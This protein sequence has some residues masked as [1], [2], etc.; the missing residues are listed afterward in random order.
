MSTARVLSTMFRLVHLD[1]LVGG[2]HGYRVVRSPLHGML[3]RRRCRVVCPILDEVIMGYNCTV[4]AYRQTGT[5]KTF[6]MEGEQSR[7]LQVTNQHVQDV[8][9]LKKLYEDHRAL[10][11]GVT[12]WHE[13]CELFVELDKNQKSKIRPPGSQT[14]E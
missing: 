14:V 2:C 11:E 12:H 10:F 13:N 3:C 5:G 7:V 6:V 1:Q 9:N 8:V 4:F